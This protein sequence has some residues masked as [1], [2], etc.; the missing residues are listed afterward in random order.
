[1]YIPRALHESSGKLIHLESP[2]M[3]V[4]AIVN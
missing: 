2:C 1:M 3:R 4:Y